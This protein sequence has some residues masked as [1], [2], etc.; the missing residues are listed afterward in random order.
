MH[1]G[2][3][4]RHYPETDKKK[5]GNLVVTKHLDKNTL[6]SPNVCNAPSS[7]STGAGNE[8]SH[9]A[10]CKMGELLHVVLVSERY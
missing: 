8:W 9:R 3:R 2:F 4:R 6:L 10:D 5:K 1:C 7:N